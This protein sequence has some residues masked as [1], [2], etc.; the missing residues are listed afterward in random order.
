VDLSA[1]KRIGEVEA[2]R[3]QDAARLA[4]LEDSSRSAAVINTAGDET[5]SAAQLA[6]GL[7]E[8]DPN[9]AD[10]TDT[11]DTAAAIILACGLKVDGASRLI[12]ILNTA[13]AA[14]LITL[15]GG[16]GV[17]IRNPE[18][19]IGQ[20]RLAHV[21]LRRTGEATLSVYIGV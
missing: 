12:A 13:D 21:L 15:A 19:T 6:G 8:R 16:T 4:V 5:Y 3:E 7:V 14:E 18:R 11:T 9:G 2:K 20:G 10:R 17:T 1:H